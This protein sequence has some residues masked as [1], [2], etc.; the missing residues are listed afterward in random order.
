MNGPQSDATQSSVLRES[1]FWKTDYVH[2]SDTAQTAL[3]SCGLEIVR[4]AHVIDLNVGV[5]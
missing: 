1:L 2:V 5:T 4:C 3:C